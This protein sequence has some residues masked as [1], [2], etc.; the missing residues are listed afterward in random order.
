MEKGTIDYIQS[1]PVSEEVR[2][3]LI[4]MVEWEKELSWSDGYATAEEQAPD[5]KH[6]KNPFF[7]KMAFEYS[8]HKSW[9]DRRPD[10]S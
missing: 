9:M 10:A 4:E 1:L 6:Q 8:I 2:R 3:T 7:E 5:T